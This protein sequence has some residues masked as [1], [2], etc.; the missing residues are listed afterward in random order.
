MIIHTFQIKLFYFR[1]IPLY[2][3]SL[4]VMRRYRFLVTGTGRCPNKSGKRQ[5]QKQQAYG[6]FHGVTSPD[7]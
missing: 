6:F 2:L 1:F 5:K 4:G 7:S 3:V